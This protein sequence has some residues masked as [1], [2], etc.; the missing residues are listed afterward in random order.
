MF[1]SQLLPTLNTTNDIQALGACRPLL[2]HLSFNDWESGTLHFALTS[3]LSSINTCSPTDT[4]TEVQA[5]LCGPDRRLQDGEQDAHECA[6]VWKSLELTPHR[7]SDAVTLQ[8][9]LSKLDDE[10]SA[11]LRRDTGLK[12][13][14]SAAKHGSCAPAFPFNGLTGSRMVCSSCGLNGPLRLSAV[15]NLRH[16][17]LDVASGSGPKRITRMPPLQR[18]YS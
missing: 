1:A 10:Y 12:H 14:P 11:Y 2:V 13:L 7:G 6:Q 17:R 15:N 3:L 9:L 5:A 4:V 18:V 8:E 16:V